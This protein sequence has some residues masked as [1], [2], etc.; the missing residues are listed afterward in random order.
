MQAVSVGVPRISLPENYGAHKIY[1]RPCIED[2][3]TKDVGG[4]R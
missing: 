3:E 1:H 4:V 2:D